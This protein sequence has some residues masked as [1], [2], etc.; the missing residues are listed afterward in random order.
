MPVRF[1]LPA[2]SAA[3]NVY[4]CGSGFTSTKPYSK[5][6]DPST[7]FSDGHVIDGDLA[8]VDNI[9]RNRPLPGAGDGEGNM[10][11]PMV[12]GNPARS[13]VDIERLARLRTDCRAQE[14]IDRI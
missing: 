11:G 3:E 14:S 8:P 7:A 10:R 5:S 1:R 4:G 9:D 13:G 2:R 6:R 12:S